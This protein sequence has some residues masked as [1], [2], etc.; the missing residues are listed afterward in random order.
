MPLDLTP[1]A[2][3]VSAALAGTTFDAVL[4]SQDGTVRSLNPAVVRDVWVEQVV[5][6]DDTAVPV[7]RDHASARPAG[8]GASLAAIADAPD[9]AKRYDVS[10]QLD[11]ADFAAGVAGSAPELPAVVWVGV[12]VSNPRRTSFAVPYVTSASDAA[13]EFPTVSASDFQFFWDVRDA[14]HTNDGTANGFYDRLVDQSGNDNDSVILINGI[15]P[16]DSPAYFGAGVTY[17]QQPVNASTSGN[18][19]I[20]PTAFANRS[21]VNQGYLAV[22]FNMAGNDGDYL[23]LNHGQSYSNSLG[24]YKITFNSAGGIEIF[25]SGSP[26]PAPSN[27]V[28][29]GITSNQT[30]LLELVLDAGTMHMYVDGGLVG[31]FANWYIPSNNNTFVNAGGAATCRYGFVATTDLTPADDVRDFVKAQATALGATIA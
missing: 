11:E 5:M 25:N 3:F 1:P 8:L 17:P 29:H 2:S 31:S 30:H 24:A 12:E 27:V 16:T 14:D 28:P 13:T 15:A 10:L 20:N 19:K 18:M 21:G 9:G 26:D 23:A 22:V 7:G 6:L 4:A